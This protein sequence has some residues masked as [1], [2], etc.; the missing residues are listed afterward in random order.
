MQNKVLSG[1]VVLDS[2][3][4]YKDDFPS[5]EYLKNDDPYDNS[6]PV[7]SKLITFNM[8]LEVAQLKTG[9]SFGELA[10]LN[11]A[12]RSATIYTLEQCH[13][14]ILNKADFT[15]IMAKVIRK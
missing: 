1:Q 11:D 10:L 13:L 14:A 15:S 3:K 8:L 4:R 12:P 7:D 6:Q 5:F 9:N 2:Q